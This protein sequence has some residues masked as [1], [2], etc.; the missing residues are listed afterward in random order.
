MLY[1]TPKCY[2]HSIKTHSDVTNENL[3]T[4][5]YNVTYRGSCSKNMK[6]DIKL[7]DGESLVGES[8]GGIGRIEVVRPK[9][10]WPVGMNRSVGHMYNLHVRLSDGDEY[11][12]PVGIR[13]VRVDG[14]RFLI[15][16]RPFYFLGVGKHE[17]WVTRGKGF[18]WSSVVKDFS[19]LEWLGANSFRTSHYPYSEEIMR[20]CDERGIVVIDECPAVGMKYEETFSDVTMR[21]HKAVMRE[22]TS[23]D[24]NHP[25]VVMWSVANGPKSNTEA[26]ANYFKVC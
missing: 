6:T 3:A 22:M 10:W 12:L 8:V 9:L 4:V 13:S 23:R 20:M 11:Q 18:D 1:T 15:N 25:S 26:T 19:L 24:Y 5:A 14:T 16:N 21:H 17:D 2:I 7:F